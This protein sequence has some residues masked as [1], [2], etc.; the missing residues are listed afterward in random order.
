MLLLTGRATIDMKSDIFIQPTGE[1]YS[2]EVCDTI[3]PDDL[4]W[5]QQ[6]LSGLR[7][8][9][10]GYTAELEWLQAELDGQCEDAEALW[11]G[12]VAD[13]TPS[14]DS[15]DNAVLISQLHCMEGVT[16]QSIVVTPSTNL[17]AA[18]LF[19]QR[20]TD[21]YNF[22]PTVVLIDVF[23]CEPAPVP[24]ACP[25]SSQTAFAE[26]DSF[27]TALEGCLTFADWLERRLT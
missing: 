23:N 11:N 17:M 5:K 7:D 19:M 16:D 14:F 15:C 1:T 13:N 9:I 3:M 22:D 10:D 2:F 12:F 6:E 26:C 18:G 20:L 27:E 21:E 8:R 24:A 4:W 25:A